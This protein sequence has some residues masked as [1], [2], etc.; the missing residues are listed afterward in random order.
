MFVLGV[1]LSA[2]TG[3]RVR[4]ICY[5]DSVTGKRVYLRRYTSISAVIDILCRKEL[6]LL[7]PQTWDDRNDRYFMDLYKDKK[8]LGG[9]YGLCTAQ[10]AETY[11]HWRVFTGN[12][13]GACIQI[14][15]S[16]FERALSELEGVRYG[17]VEYLMLDEAERLKGIDVDRLPFIKRVGFKAE[18]EYRVVAETSENQ[19]PA[20]SIEF[21]VS[22]IESIHLNPWLPRSIAQSVKD[23]ILSL[24]GCSKIR[25]SKSVLIESGRW[26]SAGD[27]VV[28]KTSPSSIVLKRRSATKRTKRQ[29]SQNNV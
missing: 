4:R 8:K 29:D 19:K 5:G 7:D 23:T 9:L 1:F 18:E 28:G 6:P 16:K 24:P 25:V 17:E 27:R 21:P 26:K 11:H 22:M 14:R 2:V 10:C 3:M 13:D 15:R 20:I 12:A